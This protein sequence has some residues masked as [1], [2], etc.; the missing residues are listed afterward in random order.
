MGLRR[1]DVEAVQGV[2]DG[3]GVRECREVGE[4]LPIRL[5]WKGCGDRVVVKGL[6]RGCGGVV[7]E[8][9]VGM[10]A[11]AWVFLER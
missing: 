11:K 10:K 3:A 2:D 1:T 7:V 5:R 6:W 8:V 9:N 4:K